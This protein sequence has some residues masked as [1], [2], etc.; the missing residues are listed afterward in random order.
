MRL[1]IAVTTCLLG[2]AIGGFA[3][4]ALKRARASGKGALAAAL[5][6]IFG[7]Y[8]AISIC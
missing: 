7:F 4:V 6:P 1:L 3:G 8:L 5:V 2:S